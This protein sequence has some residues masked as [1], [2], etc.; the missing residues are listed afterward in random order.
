MKN[1]VNMLK[2]NVFNILFGFFHK[3]VTYKTNTSNYYEKFKIKKWTEAKQRIPKTYCGR[4]TGNNLF[5]H[6]LC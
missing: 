6:L 2:F 4:G 1:I 5:R 3:L